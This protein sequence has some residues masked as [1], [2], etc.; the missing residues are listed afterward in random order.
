MAAVV[1]AATAAVG[2]P[3]PGAAHAQGHHGPYVESSQAQVACPDGVPRAGFPDVVGSTHEPSVDCVSWYEIAQGTRAG[4]YTPSQ[5][6]RRD[7]MASFVGR[8]LAAAGVAMPAPSDQGFTDIDGNPHAD[9]INQLAALDI[10][11]GTGPGTYS[12]RRPVRRDQMASFL[13]R[14]Y[15]HVHGEPLDAPPSGFT[16]TAGNPH[17]T[18]IDKAA[19]AEFVRGTTTTTYSPARPVRRDQMASFLARALERSLQDGHLTPREAPAPTLTDAT[20]LHARGVGLAEAG[21]SLTE[22]EQRTGTPMEILEFDTFGGRCYYA[23]PDGVSGYSFMVVAPGEYPPADPRQGIV[24]RVSSTLRFEPQTPTAAGVHPGES[25]AAVTDSYGLHQVQQHPHTYQPGG[26][27][28][29]VV[30]A[31]REHGLRFEVSSDDIVYAIHAGYAD[32]I[33]WPEGCA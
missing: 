31:D 15:E 1:A 13:V 30:A 16:D 18:N 9:R 29:D 11:Q 27:Y 24:V 8:A 25:P 17:A 2:A 14:A 6:V 21:I 7:Q 10:V 20:R 33:T 19:A 26:A 23:E 22:V 12:P 5:S 4:A 3:A 28:L 32:A